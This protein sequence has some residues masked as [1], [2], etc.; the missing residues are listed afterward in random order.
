MRCGWKGPRPF[1][2][3][4][5]EKLRAAGLTPGQVRVTHAS[6]FVACNTAEAGRFSHLLVRP[7]K[8]L[9]RIKDEAE[10]EDKGAGR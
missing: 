8:V 5:D 4:L 3:V 6:C 1:G 2:K 9:Y 10:L 7:D